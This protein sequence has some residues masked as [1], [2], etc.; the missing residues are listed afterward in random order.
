MGLVTTNEQEFALKKFSDYYSRAVPSVRRISEREFGFGGWDK[1]IEARHSSFLNND[2]LKSYL[3]R[4]TP[5]YI[6]YSVAFYEF[7]EARPMEKKN[8]KGAELVFDL[9]A[10]HM[11]L[12]CIAKHGKGWVCDECIEAVK[13]ETLKLIEEF[14]VP[15]F[16]LRKEEMNI[17]FSGNRGFHVHVSSDEVL[18]LDGYARREIVD[19]IM[20]TGLDEAG[21]FY[22]EGTK[23]RGP[24]LGEGGWRG[25]IA[26]TFAGKLEAQKLNELGIHTRTVNRFYE[27][28]Q[29]VK[30]GLANGNWDVIHLP[31][32]EEFWREVSAK[33]KVNLGD[34][35]D[36]M[37]TP[38]ATKLIRVPDSLHGE[39]GLAARKTNCLE[40][41][42][43]LK[44][45]VV[46]DLKGK[47]N[48]VRVKVL[49]APA[50]RLGEQTFGPYENYTLTLP[51]AA[52]IYLLCK[53][54]AVLA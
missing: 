43:A 14:L 21:V 12:A 15:D 28:K 33:L 45:A 16:G 23:M 20:G 10:D 9:D 11:P 49:K 39:T 26:R 32:P 34:Q 44:D 18:G 53:K 52:A 6:S 5:L 51:E 35:I 54:A 29:E 30:E 40:K 8:W 25:K 19:Y 24:K 38:D 46:F 27:K 7:P 42:D 50:F 47:A 37:V 31:K 1:K 17:N 41:F 13:N 3:V 48:G 36:Q 4:N 2:E 22:K